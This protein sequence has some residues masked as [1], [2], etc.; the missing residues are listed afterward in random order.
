MA[1]TGP[2]TAVWVPMTWP[3]LTRGNNRNPENSSV[4]IKTTSFSVDFRIAD[5]FDE[6]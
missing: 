6:Y 2:G 3:T 5:E 1:C 4:R